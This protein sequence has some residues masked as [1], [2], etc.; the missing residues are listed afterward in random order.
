VEVGQGQRLARQHALARAEG[1]V[2]EP[3]GRLRAVAYHRLEGDA[4]VHVVH[5]SGLGDH[6]LAGAQLDLDDLQVVAED[7]EVDVV[8]HGPMIGRAG[9]GRSDTGG[10]TAHVA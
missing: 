4:I 7:A 3:A 10:S 1:L 9:A 6:R 8:A 2:P 5:G